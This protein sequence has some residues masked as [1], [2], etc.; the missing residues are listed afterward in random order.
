MNRKL[1]VFLLSL[2]IL[3]GYAQLLK[4]SLSITVRDEVGNIV[5]GADIAMYETADDYTK[6]KNAVF[7]A[8]TDE[9]GMVKFKDVKPKGYFVVVRKDDKD[10]SGGGEQTGVLESG[11]LNKVTIIIQ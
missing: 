1:S 5:T 10:N 4:T 8:I 7:T 3:A 2:T 11:K 9:K 6:E